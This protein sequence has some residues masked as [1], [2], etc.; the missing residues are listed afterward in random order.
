ML[1]FGCHNFINSMPILYGLKKAPAGCSLTLDNP[2][3]IARLLH[4]GRLDV[5]IVPAIEYLL[6][7]DYLIVPP[8]CIA[9]KGRVESVNLYHRG[10]I[11]KIRHIALDQA[12]LTSTVL[13]RI[14]MKRCF[15]LRPVYSPARSTR[16]EELP[17]S[18]TDATLIIG[19][20]ALNP[21]PAGYRVLDLAEQWRR[22]TNLPFVFAVCCARRG[23]DLDGF[24]ETLRAS[25]VEGLAHVSEI[26]CAAAEPSLPAER[27]E[28]YF[29][30]SL[31]YVLGKE[32]QEGLKRFY[33]EV[34]AGGFC[35]EERDLEFYPC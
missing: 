7:A 8:V 22:M 10:P 17:R 9:A 27:L 1:R 21:P 30:K 24:S 13:I 34:V 31:R 4:E 18:E 3:A 2:R 29:I 12:S 26:A 20:E 25:L 15:R 16:L 19:D 23:A 6:N 11:E 35:P 5:A 33:A 28:S 32:E 14:I